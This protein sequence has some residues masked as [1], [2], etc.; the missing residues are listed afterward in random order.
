M[1]WVF[2]IWREDDDAERE[3]DDDERE[4]DG[5][6]EDEVTTE[7]EKTKWKFKIEKSIEEEKSVMKGKGR[8]YFLM[9]HI[10]V[11]FLI[12]KGIFIQFY[13]LNVSEHIF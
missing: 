13:L 11:S 10:A 1:I 3:D 9:G 6:R 2:L 12:F 7:R 5:E 4:E 8:E